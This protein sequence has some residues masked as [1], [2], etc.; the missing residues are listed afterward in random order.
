MKGDSRPF[1]GVQLVLC[2]D[3]FQLPPVGI[4]S[5][6]VNFCFEA[7]T[8]ESSLDQC[9]V[10]KQVFRQKDPRFLSILHEMREGKISNKSQ[11]ILHQKRGEDPG[12]G[13]VTEVIDDA[14][15]ATGEKAVVEV[16]CGVEGKP[17]V[18]GGAVLPTKL[19]S[20]N[21]DVDR[22]NNSELQRLTG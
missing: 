12:T 19:F 8:W 15:G 5:N 17:E 16:H 4:G 18:T 3:F 10:L 6:G 21:M 7:K 20:R 2:G 9:I 22:L 14:S 11:S 13:D 1:G